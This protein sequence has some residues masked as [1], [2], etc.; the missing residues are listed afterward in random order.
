MKVNEIKGMTNS[1]LIFFL[2]MN[3]R[4]SCSEVN[5]SRGLTKK[6]STETDRILEECKLRG[7]LTDE[8]AQ[9]I[10]D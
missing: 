10:L 3:D 7:L 2:V 8:H 5:S 9:K 4:K 6:T 1:E